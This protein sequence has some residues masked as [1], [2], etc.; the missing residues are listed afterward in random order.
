MARYTR[1][2]TRAPARRARTT[3]RARYSAA[4]AYARRSGRRTTARRTS[5]RSSAPRDIR[6]II[7]QPNA[8][9]VARPPSVDAA[10]ALMPSNAKPQKAKF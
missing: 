1:R 3:S 9:L 2:T 10:R 5:G 4:P 7:E 8:N 6:I